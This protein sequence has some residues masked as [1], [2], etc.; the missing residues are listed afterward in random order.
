MRIKDNK[1]FYIK[2][3]MFTSGV[4]NTSHSNS[5]KMLREYSLPLLLVLLPDMPQPLDPDPRDSAAAD[6]PLPEEAEPVPEH[7]S[8]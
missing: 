8:S 1:D 4:C 3:L 6:T 2:Q 7:A 5:S